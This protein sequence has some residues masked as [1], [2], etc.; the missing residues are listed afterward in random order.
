MQ[1]RGGKKYYIILIGDCIRYCYFYLLRSK[2]ETLEIVKH[3]KNKVEYQLNKKLKVI[4]NDRGGKYN[5]SFGEF[6]FQNG[7]IL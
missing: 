6:C 5:A 1:T 4:K 7:I 3:C 2:D